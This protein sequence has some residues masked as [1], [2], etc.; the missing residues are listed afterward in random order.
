MSDRKGQKNPNISDLNKVEVYIS[1][2][3]TKSINKKAGIRLTVWGSH[4][5]ICLRAV[6]PPFIFLPT[7]ALSLPRTFI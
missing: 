6:E 3:K 2:T 5:H 4:G 1:V 7:L